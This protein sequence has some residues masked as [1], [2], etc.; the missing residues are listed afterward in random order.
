MKSITLKLVV[1]MLAS[2]AAMG[3]TGGAAFAVS[4]SETGHSLHDNVVAEEPISETRDE[5]VT[6]AQERQGQAG[7]IMKHPL[8]V[9]SRITGWVSHVRAA[10]GNIAREAQQQALEGL[11]TAR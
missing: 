3:M 9:T 2:L 5:A 10:A 1:G 7:E 8:S 6:A 11:G 4:L